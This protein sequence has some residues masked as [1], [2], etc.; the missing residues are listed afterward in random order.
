MLSREDNETLTRIGPGT[1][2]GNFFRQY[3]LPALLSSELP[4]LDGPPKRLRIL[5]EDLIAFRDTGGR[6]GLLADHCS[7][8]G[9]SLFFGRNEEVGLRCVYHGWKYDVDGRCIDMPNEPPE[10]NFRDKIRHP[11]YPCREQNGTIWTYLGPRKDPPPLPDLEWLSLPPG[12]YVFQKTMRE[13]NWAQAMEGDMDDAHVSFLHARFSVGAGDGQASQYMH[14]RRAPELDVR[15][16]EAGVMYAVRRDAGEEN[17]WRIKHWLFPS[18]SM[19]TTGTP[20]DRRT[21]P[22]HMW[23]PIDDENTMQWGVRWNPTEPLTDKQIEAGAVSTVEHL[24]NGTGY[25]D[26]WR[27]VAN[28]TNDYLLDYELQRTK[29]FSGVPAVPLQ[30]KAITESMGRILDRSRE[31]LGSTDAMVIR[32]RRRLL[33][34]AKE[35]RDEGVTPPGVDQPELYRV[36]SAIINLAKEADWVEQTREILKA[37]SGLPACSTVEDSR[38]ILNAVS[39]SPTASTR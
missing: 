11:A 38:E 12:H 7:H 17:N 35:L 29:Q 10:S 37:F 3:W 13:C 20:G 33:A 23:V 39:G 14:T 34:M 25:L 16:T 8:R 26:Q 32:I 6:V 31:H 36:R 15:D 27:P 9:A 2:M 5:G 30:D 18:F 1:P 22:G 4:A 19:I 24:P 28:S 21:L